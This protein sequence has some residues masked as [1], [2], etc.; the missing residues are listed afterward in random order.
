MQGLLLEHP[1]DLEATGNSV[2][3]AKALASAIQRGSVVRDTAFLNNIIDAVADPIL[4][5]DSRLRFVLVNQALCDF[6][7][8]PRERFVS[9]KTRDPA[10]GRIPSSI[11]IEGAQSRV[12]GPRAQRRQPC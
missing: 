11:A 9:R 7:G 2:P 12:L 6:T 4:V 3:R 8:I 5:K 1:I 10:F